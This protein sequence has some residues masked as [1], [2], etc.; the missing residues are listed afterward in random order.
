MR[1]LWVLWR[2]LQAV[3]FSGFENFRRAGGFA[4]FHERMSVFMGRLLETRMLDYFPT[5]EEGNIYSEAN[6]CE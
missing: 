3:I 4:W 1:M 5:S 2:T 6:I